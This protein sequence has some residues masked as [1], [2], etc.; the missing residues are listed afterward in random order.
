MLNLQFDESIC[1]MY[2]YFDI[3]TE[4]NEYMLDATYAPSN[5]RYLWNIV[6]KAIATGLL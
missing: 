2:E 4:A 6:L 3:I 5:I 1:T